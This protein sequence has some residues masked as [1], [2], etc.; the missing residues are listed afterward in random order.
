MKRSLLLLTA[1]LGLATAAS[2]SMVTLNYSGSFD[3]TSTLGGTAFGA[4]TPFT[5]HATFDSAQDTYA[6]VGVGIFNIQSLSVQLPS[7]SYTAEPGGN[8]VQLMDL[9]GFW[10]NVVIIG[11]SSGG[12]QSLFSAA[13]PNFSADVP[14]ASALSGDFWNLTS[15]N[16][17][18]I[19]LDGAQG[20]LVIKGFGA[21]PFTADIT[22]PAA[23][24]E[25]GQWAMMG[26]TFCGVAGYGFRRYRAS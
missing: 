25:P 16:P 1:S 19:V 22:G 21:G 15:D 3:P 8:I 10:A 4:D 12:I 14:V 24:P 13:T 17:Y 18:A 11:S 2:A 6:N 9:T 7:G 20:D 5:F 23:V 26:L